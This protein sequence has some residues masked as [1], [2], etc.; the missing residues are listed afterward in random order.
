M[1]QNQSNKY[2]SGKQERIIASALGW[3]VV[4]GSGARSL[5]PG[6]IQSDEWLGECKTHTKPGNKITF[7]KNVWDKIVDEA[8]SRY[9]FPALFVDDG[10]QKIENT[11]V[12]YNTMPPADVIY[13]GYPFTVKTNISFE[14]LD[15]MNHR[16]E[17]GTTKSVV[18]PLQWYNKFVYISNLKDF[19]DM[20]SLV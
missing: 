3:S 18:Y 8:I 2:F 11:W 5:H 14:S 7:Y 13:C 17:M 20:F 19:I 12:L 1:S 6:D 4:P 9:K 10:S 16:K 15:M